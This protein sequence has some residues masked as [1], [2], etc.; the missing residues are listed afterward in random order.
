MTSLKI[1]DGELWRVMWAMRAC[2]TNQAYRQDSARRWVSQPPTVIDLPPERFAQR[3]ADAELDLAKL[4][5]IMAKFPES[6]LRAWADR[7][8][9][10]AHRIC[11]VCRFKIIARAATQRPGWTNGNLQIAQWLSR[12]TTYQRVCVIVACRLLSCH[13]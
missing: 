12:V 10:S 5:G 7:L 9:R 13:H 3:A 1:D 2:H 8:A 11:P 4:D 6:L